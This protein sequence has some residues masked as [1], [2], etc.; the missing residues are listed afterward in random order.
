[1][2]NETIIVVSHGESVNGFKHWARKV[3]LDSQIGYSQNQWEN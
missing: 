1:M 3:I 2:K